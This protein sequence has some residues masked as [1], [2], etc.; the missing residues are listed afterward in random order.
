[1]YQHK[2]K[3]VKNYFVKKQKKGVNE[4]F[5]SHRHFPDMIPI[6]AKQEV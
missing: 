5:F 2:E 1:M 6:K 3:C 4:A